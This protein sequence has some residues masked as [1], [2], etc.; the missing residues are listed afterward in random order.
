MAVLAAVILLLLLN[1]SEVDYYPGALSEPP[2]R[3]GPTGAPPGASEAAAGCHHGRHPLKEA[4]G[5]ATFR[6]VDRNGW[7]RLF[8]A[9]DVALHFDDPAMFL[10]ALENDTCAEPSGEWRVTLRYRDEC[11]T[12]WPV[13][14]CAGEIPR[15]VR[16]L[17]RATLVDQV[18]D[19]F[20]LASDERG[21]IRYPLKVLGAGREIGRLGKTQ[22]ILWE[23]QG[24]PQVTYGP[25]GC[26]R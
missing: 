20:D 5:A 16:L 10:A 2:I 6:V 26:G 7:Y 12:P 23:L 9:S 11:R 4:V 17:Y 3:E 15:E 24:R 25:C 22:F 21:L 14:F 13:L 1:L 19:S 8:W 18:P